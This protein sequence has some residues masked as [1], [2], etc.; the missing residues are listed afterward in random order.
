[1][2][3][4]FFTIIFFISGFML[5]QKVKVLDQQTGKIVKNTTIFNDK[6]TINITTDINGFADISEFKNNEIVVFSHLSYA[7]LRIKKSII[8][9]KNYII[10]LTKESEQLDEVV[11]S[12]FKKEEKTARIAEQIAVLNARDI[13]KVSPQ[14]S[15]DLL[16]TIPGIKV[17]KSQ[18]GGGSPVIRGMESNRVLLVV[19]GVRMNNAIYRKGHLQSSITVTP[20]MLDK[21]EVVFG[22]S[23]VVYGSDALGGV[24][25]YYTKTPKLSQENEVES[26]LFS[27]FSTVNQEVTTNVSAEIRKENWASLTSVSY[28]DFGDL[29]AGKNRSHGFKDW[30]RVFFFS[31]NINGNYNENPTKNSNSNIQRNTGYKQTDILQ[32]FFIPLSKN[33]DLKVN[34]QYSTSSDIPRFDRLAELKDGE[35]KFAEWFYGPQKRFLASTQLI[36]NPSKSWLESGVITAAYQNLE[37]SRIQRKFGSLNRFYREE[38]VDV[39]SLNGD[40]SIALT[41]D[42]RRT[43]SYGFEFAYNDV[44][45]NA[46]GKELN[47]VNGEIDGFSNDFKAQSRYPDGGSNY[48]SSAAYIDYRQDIN[49]KSTL[50]SGIRF[51]NTNLNAT[52]KDQT[53]IH[54]AETNIQANHSAVTA[55]LGYVYKPNKNWQINSVISSG[56]RAPNIDDIGRVREKAGTVTVPNVSVTPEFAYNAEIGVQK[57][58]NDKKFRFGAN[59][60]YTLLDNYIQRD[61]VYNING[62]IKQVEFDGEFGS[63][64]SNQNKDKAYIT[65]FTANYLG[66]ISNSWRTSGFITYT[67]GKTYDTNEPM[68]SIPPLFGQ[69]ELNHKVD[70]FELG[71]AIR[72]NSKKNIK[73]FNITEGIDNHDLTPIVNENT[74]EDLL[75]YAG[76]PSWI[77]AGLNFRFMVNNNFSVLARLDNLLNEHYIEFAS[78]VASPGRNLSVS[79]MVNF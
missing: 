69:F 76:S 19:D 77:T 37:E 67:K 24:I 22:P 78:G 41:A 38:A 20:N 65:G 50:N 33:T 29:K 56:F 13:Q 1:M 21:T 73:D 70:R 40:F 62:S 4:L 55:T 7:V 75:K 79:F 59:I 52:W 27:R 26:Q 47:I 58:F 18:F 15:A 64:I 14:T 46:Y 8:K 34:I 66:K 48:L 60:Y 53:F 5:A 57:Y 31:E 36:L 23:S 71:A 35:L 12:L 44:N 3:N 43:L 2:K 61:F 45:S 68:S 72:F 17:Q 63:A 51:T 30:G 9:S 6:E 28:S 42:K 32:K 39:F 74:T 10:Y 49:S 11:I 54:L 16:A 25:H